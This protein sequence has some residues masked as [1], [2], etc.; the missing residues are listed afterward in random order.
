MKSGICGCMGAVGM[1]LIAVSLIAGIACGQTAI[2]EDGQGRADIVIAEKPTRGAKLAAAELQYFIEKIS[3]AKLPIL[4]GPGNAAPVHI[5]VGA[6]SHTKRLGVSDEGLKY[7]AFKMVS[8]D[9]WFVL[10]GRDVELGNPTPFGRNNGRYKGYSLS[11]DDGRGSLNAVYAFLRTLGCRWYFPGEIG[12]ILPKLETVALPQVNETVRPD[13]AMRHMYQYYNVFYNTHDDEELLWQFRLGFNSGREVMGTTVGH[14]INAVHRSAEVKKNHPEW[15]AIW[16]GERA[17]N[18]GHG[19]GAPCLSSE[20]LFKANVEYVRSMFDRGEPMIS[21]APCDGYGS[22]CQCELCKGKDTPDRGWNGVLSDYVWDYVNRVAAEVYKTHPD[23]K[24]TCIA[25]STYLL[26]PLKIEKLSPNVV[27]I[28]CRWRSD[29]INPVVHERYKKLLN[30][31]LEKAPSKQVFIWDYYLHGRPEGSRYAGIPVYFTRI[32]DEDLKSLKGISGGE[33]IE[34]IR[35]WPADN[36]PWH[37]L[38]CNHLNVYVTARLW[39]DADQDLDALLEEYYKNFYGPAAEEMKAFVDY[40]ETNWPRS[41][42]D[43]TVI[44]RFVELLGAAQAAAGDTIY[45]KRIDMISKFI[46]PMIARRAEVDKGRDDAPVAIAARREKAD[47]TLDGKLDENFWD[48]LE[49]YPLREI[50]R[51][52]EPESTSSF[53]VACTD[54]FLCFGIRCEDADMATLNIGTTRNEDPN[55]WNGDEVELMLETATHA[56]YQIAI[57]PA[58]AIVDADWKHEF[59]TVWSSNAEAAVHIG[60][61]FWSVEVRVPIAGEGQERVEPNQG[62]SGNVPSEEDPWFFNVYRQRA[63]GNA[64][65]LSAFSPT[66]SNFLQ[67]DKFGKLIAK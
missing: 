42:K 44:D 53:K 60:E 17:I 30:S 36:R 20:G 62:V 61:D 35:N 18:A 5:Y 7:D 40:S 28:L 21:V 59:N 29:F 54:N 14:G 47:I 49:S 4:S 38:A 16:G 64:R 25:Y 1:F 34:C 19:A 65:E 6:S 3:G 24:I 33:F 56:Y 48:G 2:V 12:E 50:R 37:A 15:F 26:P 43:A 52:G 46:Q 8:G 51:G 67:P 32:I 22:L 45:G 11:K 58:A 27:I 13:F 23:K 66:G 39:W 10:L 41:L 63:R 57:S 55:I 31:W 9:N